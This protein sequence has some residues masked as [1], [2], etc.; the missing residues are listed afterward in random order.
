MI[1]EDA[2]QEACG[3]EIPAWQNQI[4]K[5]KEETEAQLKSQS[6]QSPGSLHV[7]VVED[8]Y[9]NQTVVS[10]QLRKD[11]HIVHVANHGEDAIK[12]IQ[13]SS[14]WNSEFGGSHFRERLHV[15]LMDL[16]M[17]VRLMLSHYHF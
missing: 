2:L 8:N 12:F 5:Q 17:P 3:S 14:F 16:E 1:R 10:K 4:R 7:L 13:K 11:G 9:V 6:L 15:V